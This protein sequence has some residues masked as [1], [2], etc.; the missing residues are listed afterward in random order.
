MSRFI[1]A[2]TI[3]SAF[4]LTSLTSMAQAADYGEF[5]GEF[6]GGYDS[7]FEVDNGLD[8]IGFELGLRYFYSVGEHQMRI[9]NDAYSSSDTSHIFE[10]HGRIDDYSTG[11]YVKGVAGYSALIDGN[12]STPATGGTIKM[13]GGKIAYAGADF[14][15][16]GF[17]SES[18]GFGGFA[19]YQ[20]WNDSPDMGRR[21]Y[22]N[23]SG[24]FST[25][26]DLT[27]QMLRLGLVAHADLGDKVDLSIEA[28]FVPYARLTGD[29]GAFAMTPNQGSYGSITGN[30]WG[31][32]A[33]AMV[34]FHPTDN[35]TIR[36][37]GRAWY[38]N[39]PADMTFD[40]YDGTSSQSFTTKVSDYSLLRAGALLE[41]TYRY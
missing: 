30:L 23:A 19:G 28:A 1:Q 37:G 4:S 20:Y 3:L 7:K 9:G 29:Y 24:S 31:A 34:G 15:Y 33:E 38:L 2:I 8:P 32:S 39:G 35:L 21:N 26:N 16:I 22:T 17:G 6:R 13:N 40:T 10:L 12:Y 41:L 27:Y 11:T 18:F 36:A 5:P 25:T 14:G